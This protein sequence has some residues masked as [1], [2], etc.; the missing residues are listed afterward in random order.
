VPVVVANRGALPEVAGPAARL[1]DPTDAA[2]LA[3]ALRDVLGDSS[4]RQRMAEAGWTQAA[5]Y[6]WTATASA[7]RNA[8]KL[9]LAHRQERRG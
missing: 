5:R 9:A 2:A 4:L 7:L 6:T 3:A 1:F 8:W